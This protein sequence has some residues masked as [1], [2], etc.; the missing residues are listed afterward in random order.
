MAK[1]VQ[2]FL[3]YEIQEMLNGNLILS[4]NATNPVPGCGHFGK[5]LESAKMAAI[6]LFMIARPKLFESSIF[7]RMSGR[8]GSYMEWHTF[9]N[10]LKDEGIEMPTD[11]MRSNDCNALIALNLTTV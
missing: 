5:D 9:Q 8:E 10:C 11:I 2:K 3:D 7:Y 6:R 1:L 4:K